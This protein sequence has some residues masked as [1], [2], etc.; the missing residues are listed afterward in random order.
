MTYIRHTRA[1]TCLQKW[2][3]YLV[4]KIVDSCTTHVIKF[5]VYRTNISPNQKVRNVI[6]QVIVSRTY[7]SIN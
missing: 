2:K 6:V 5:R 4:C 3:A 7:I 1:G